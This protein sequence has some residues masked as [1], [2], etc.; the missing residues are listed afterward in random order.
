[1]RFM[2]KNLMGM[3]GGGLGGGGFDCLLVSSPTG[4]SVSVLPSVSLCRV[5]FYLALSLLLGCVKMGWDGMV[6]ESAW[7]TGQGMEGGLADLGFFALLGP[8]LGCVEG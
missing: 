7:G 3:D 8:A 6:Y 2:T 4:F 1:M 5:L